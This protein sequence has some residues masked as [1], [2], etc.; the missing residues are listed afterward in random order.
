VS[1][2]AGK[3]AL[4]TGAS[5]GLGRVI[6]EELG[7]E[8]AAVACVGRDE[9]LLA[10]TVARLQS[11]GGRG[12]AAEADVRLERDVE[13][14]VMSAVDVFGG[15]DLLVNAA[16]VVLTGPLV[17]ASVEDWDLLFDTNTKGCFL[18]CKHAIPELRRRGGGAV[19]NV[20]S[21][22]AFAADAGAAAYSASKAA[23][24]MLTQI[25]ALEHISE[26]IRVNGVAPGTMPTPMI[27]AIAESHS[28]E[29]PQSILDSIDQ[30][31]PLGRMVRPEE[32]AAVVL[33]LLSDHASAIVGQTYV[34]DGG[35]LAKLG[36]AD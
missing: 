12:L 13:R 32:V 33:F 27:Q 34:V 11:I 24:A 10:E 25:L 17:D 21:V 16:G 3:V 36:S 26:G 7:A 28:P 30:L 9:A 8:G 29:N 5:R 18:F 23:V 22:Y 4:V 15:L 1:R 20:S 19:V 35:R 31:H 14:A 2:F 6:A